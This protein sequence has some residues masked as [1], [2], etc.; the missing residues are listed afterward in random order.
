MSEHISDTNRVH[1]QGSVTSIVC[2]LNALNV[3][4]LLQPAEFL[5]GL[6]YYRDL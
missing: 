2:C 6:G 1:N 4:D 5:I 3:L